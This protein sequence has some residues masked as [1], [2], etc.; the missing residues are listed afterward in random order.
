MGKLNLVSEQLS[1]QA[2][3]QTPEHVASETGSVRSSQITGNEQITGAEK[4]G[5]V[6]CLL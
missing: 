2:E 6:F 4:P 1:E 5:I 3:C